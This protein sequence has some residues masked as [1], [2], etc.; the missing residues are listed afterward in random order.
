LAPTLAEAVALLQV[1]VDI[2]HLHL[3]ICQFK[4]LLWMS[5]TRG[6]WGEKGMLPIPQ[7]PKLL[8]V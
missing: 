3:H 8:S 6:K 2:M 5:K 7:F 1:S 4:E